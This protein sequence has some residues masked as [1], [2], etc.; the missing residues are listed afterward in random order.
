MAFLAAWHT[1]AASPFVALSMVSGAQASLFL[2]P[3]GLGVY[4][5]ALGIT[6]TQDADI[7][8]T[9]N[10]ANQ[11]AWAAGLTL[12]GESDWRLP[13]MDVNGDDVIADCL[14]DTQ[15]ACIDNEYGHLFYYGAGT[16]L[17]DGVTAGSPD[18]FSNVQS[19]VY[20][21][22]TELAGGPNGAW[23]F[24]FSNGDQGAQVKTNSRSAWAVADGNVFNAVV[25]IPASVWL[26]GS[27]L[28]LLGWM[29]R[30]AV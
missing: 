23:V 26:F 15:A 28:G 25:P 11:S 3:N 20:W 9:D 17:L 4:D 7:N 19:G 30:K 6:W 24:D 10:W 14:S 29:R 2:A 22:G 5:T 12:G 27:A 13:N 21:S 18:P 1:E 16:T 8:S